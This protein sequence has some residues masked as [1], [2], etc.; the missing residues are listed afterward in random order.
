M[1]DIWIEKSLSLK[2]R[3]GEI[4][5]FSW[6]SPALVLNKHFTELPDDPMV[7]QPPFEQFSKTQEII[8]MHS[9]PVAYNI[10]R[11]RILPHAIRYV[12]SQYNHF[13]VELSGKFDDY[14]QKFSSKSRNTLT[15]KLKKFSKFSEGEIV[16]REFLHPN[17]MIEFHHLALK[18]SAKSY[19][20]KLLGCGLPVEIEFRNNI[21]KLAEQGLARGYI[22]FHF[23]KPIAYIFC[24]INDG[25]VFYEYVGH[26]PDFQQWSPGSMLQYFALKNLFGIEKL[27]LFDFTEGEGSHKEF[28][29]NKN[30]LC[31]DI[32]YFRRTAQ[33]LILIL[34]HAGISSISTNAVKI[35]EK[36]GLKERIKKFFRSAS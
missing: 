23:D 6:Q 1:N 9:H 4:T 13:W 35:L 26:D 2:F 16:W 25:I 11:L 29:S 18:V 34:L 19:Q 7:P 22:L 21:I 28:F 8:A 31:A 12:P 20:E 36:F 30:K 17:E 33:N 5:L 27:R 15:R 14:I 3:L 10:P 24:P 32:Y